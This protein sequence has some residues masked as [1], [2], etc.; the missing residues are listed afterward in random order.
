MR[1]FVL[2]SGRMTDA[3]KKAYDELMPKYGIFSV[4]SSPSWL[5]SSPLICEIGFGMGQATIDIAKANP[6]V[7]YLGIEVFK[8]GIGKLLLEIEKQQIENIRIIEGDA[9]EVL[10]KMIS[11]HS[12]DG[13]HIF[14]P[15]PWPK[16]KHHKRRLVTRPFTN[17]LAQKLKDNG[18]LYMATDWADYAD[19]ALT[20]L[21][22]TE[23]LRNK[24]DGFADKQEWR[25]ETKFERKG[26]AKEH[27]I[28][29][30]YFTTNDTNRLRRHE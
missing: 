6:D 28:Y 9:V 20:E 15:D 4:N 17:L 24:Y 5:D 25:P 12:I 21:S 30:L 13:F 22:A 23:G 18:Y 26:L 1:S 7:H 14:F 10:E 16:K 19:W 3:Q 2:R 8:A 11:D 27:K 29:E